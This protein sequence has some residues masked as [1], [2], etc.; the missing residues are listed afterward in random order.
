M[1]DYSGPID[2]LLNMAKERSGNLKTRLSNAERFP[3]TA[4]SINMDQHS[5]LMDFLPK[6]HQY[7]I[8]RYKAVSQPGGNHTGFEA[9]VRMSLQS[10][11]AI[12]VWLKSMAIAWRVAYTRPRKG[13]RIIFKADYRCQYNTKPRKISKP[14]RLSKNTDCPAKLKVTLVRTEVSRGQQSRSTDP[15]IPDYPTLVDISNIHNH[16][17]HVA[18]AMCH[19]DVGKEAVEKLNPPLSN[20][21]PEITMAAAGELDAEAPEAVLDSEDWHS[22]IKELSAMMLSNERFQAAASAFM[23]TFHSLKENPYMLQL[24]MHMFGHYGAKSLAAPQ[25]GNCAGQSTATQ[26]ASVAH[27]KVKHGRKRPLSAG[28]LRKCVATM[29]HRYSCPEGVKAGTHSVSQAVEVCHSNPK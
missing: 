28:C 6:D 17:I 5:E 4:P 8:C 22:T 21:S 10:K 29:D 23:K 18:D 13:Q 24:A 27:P 14:G 12:L 15:H 1:S 9:T 7:H 11:D 26:P 3:C 2:N 25:D 20:R 19:R 16:N